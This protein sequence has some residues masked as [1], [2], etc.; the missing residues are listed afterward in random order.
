MSS[1]WWSPWA[2]TSWNESSVGPLVITLDIFL[3][4]EASSL[5]T[6]IVLG[7]YWTPSCGPW[8]L[9]AGGWGGSEL[10]GISSRAN[11][12]FLSDVTLT[13]TWVGGSWIAVCV[14]S[15][16]ALCQLSYCPCTLTLS[17]AC[18]SIWES[19]VIWALLA[20]ITSR[21]LFKSLSSSHI[22]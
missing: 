3:A 16:L 21:I 9:G 15:R 2:R 8:I 5:V 17:M 6:L 10:W 20:C 19:T 4:L 7:K 11:E 14:C 12:S 1:I 18:K 22:T 13:Y